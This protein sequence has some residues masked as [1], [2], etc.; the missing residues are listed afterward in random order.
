MQRS[1]NT[2]EVV[3]GELK[4]KTLGKFG[5]SVQAILTQGCGT[6]YSLNSIVPA[7]INPFPSGKVLRVLVF[8]ISLATWNFKLVFHH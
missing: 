7:F 1:E 6:R 5:A 8:Q 4:R 2:V 3:E